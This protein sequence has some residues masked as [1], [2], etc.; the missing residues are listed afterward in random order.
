MG[1]ETAIFA[2]AVVAK[3]GESYMDVKSARAQDSAIDLEAKQN[4]LQ[5]QQKTLE[6]YDVMEKLVDSQIANMTTKGVAFSSPSFNAIQRETLN[7]GARQGKNIEIEGSIADEN[8]KIEKQ[9]VRNQLYSKLFGN[10]GDIATGYAGFSS[11]MPTS[12]A[13]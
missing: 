5:T 11:K 12:G 8:A 2:A 1:I 7:T 10:V 6:N 9:N 4:Q 3:A 13:N